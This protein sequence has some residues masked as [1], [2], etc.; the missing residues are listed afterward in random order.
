[1]TE[2]ARN[3]DERLERFASE[4]EGF[5]NGGPNLKHKRLKEAEE[6]G[7]DPDAIA[8][9][10]DSWDKAEKAKARREAEPPSSQMKLI[11]AAT[12]VASGACKE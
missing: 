9:L 6:A 11:G 10:V 7:L 12:S 3:L 5:L 8:T 4:I 1:M 2:V